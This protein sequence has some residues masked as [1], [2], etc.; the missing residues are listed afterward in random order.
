[1]PWSGSGTF[2]LSDTLANATPG[3][4]DEVQAILDDIATGLSNTVAKDGQ[5]TMTAPLKASNG[6]AAAPSYTF[7]S[8]TDSGFYRIGANS[9]GVSVNGALLATFDSAGITLA[10]GA[11]VGTGIIGTTALAANAVTLAKMATQADATV[12]ANVSGSTAVPTAV[13]YTALF[14]DA[15]GSTQG[16][17]IYKGATD[18][19]AL[20]PGTSGYFLKTQGAGANPTWAALNELPSG[21]NGHVL[22][23]SGGAWTSSP[24][25]SIR[26]R[27]SVTNGTSATCT[28]GT[29]AVN[30]A[31]VTLS[32]S[33]YTVTFTSALAS[34]NYQVLISLTGTGGSNSD[35]QHTSVVKST[36]SFTFNV[37]RS[38]T[39]GAGTYTAFDFIVLGGF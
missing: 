16:Q 27:A 33:T 11:I 24:D 17:I 7:G 34:T 35:S 12:L 1:M 29:G 38:S 9:V 3:D 18:W 15:F 14:N 8:D 22:Q 13:G 6:S 21:T 30:V 2:A 19:A 10:S 37:I 4:A 31:S 36:G 32:G 20:A 26:A 25:S 23:Y 39:N 5:S 28:V